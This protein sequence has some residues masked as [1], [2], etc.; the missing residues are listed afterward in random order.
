[1][2]AGLVHDAAPAAGATTATIA[3]R[4][5]KTPIEDAH[6]HPRLTGAILQR[7]SAIRPAGTYP[8][9][10]EGR[11][12]IRRVAAPTVAPPV[13]LVTAL[14]GLR[15]TW[16][17]PAAKRAISA[18]IVV[19]GLFALSSKVIGDPQIATYAAFGGFATLV[20]AGFGGTRRDKL[21][22]HAGLAVTGSV[23]LVI[24]TAVNSIT[25][26]AALVTLLVGFCVLFAG[27]LSANAASGATAALLAY[28]L[29]AASPGTIG[30]I[31]A[32][33]AG[34]WMASVAGTLAVLFLYSPPP[35]NRLRQAAWGLAQSIADLL[36]AA[37][38]GRSTPPKADAVVAAKHEL[39]A[40]FTG[41]PYRPTGLTVPDQAIAGLVEALQWCATSATQAVAVGS[42]NRLAGDVDPRLMVQ[43]AVVLRLV[44]EL[45]A[46]GEAR[47]L[48]GAVREL[49]AMLDAVRDEGTGESPETGHL[50]FHSRLVAAAT[51]S[52]AYDA[53]IAARRMD[54]A[55]AAEEVSQWWGQPVRT[56]GSAI[57]HPIGRAAS[58]VLGGH[59]SLRSIWFLNSA[60]GAVALAA[61]VAI[62]DVTNVQHAFWVVLGALSVLRTS[63]AATGATALRALVGTAIGFLIGAVL[64]VE[65]GSHSAAL[66]AVLPVAVLIAA[67]APGTAPF[68]IGQAAFT[69]TI[70]VL[71]NLIVPV[72]WKVGEV[73]IEDVAIGVG[74]SVAA[75]ALFWPR[76]ATR[77]VAQDLSEAFHAGGLYLVQAAAWA[78][79]AR[80]ESPDA[81]STVIRAEARLDDAMRGL[82]S[83]QGTKRV[84]KENVWRLVGGAQRLRL[85]AHTLAR[86]GR[87]EH[88]V[89]EEDTRLL[90]GEAARVAG[91]YDGMAA[92]LGHSPTTVAQELASLR[93]GEAR[94]DLTVPR[95][96]WVSQ[97]I[98]HLA[99]NLS[100]LEA[101][102]R[103]MATAASRPWWR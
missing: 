3:A 5:P 25:I 81:A 8:A 103:I 78:L 88:R 17:V 13:R 72:G 7:F 39:L 19:P 45:T 79:G 68:A 49:A 100:D 85:M 69:V 24:G 1:M 48:E 66:W 27:V 61:A 91:L 98:D 59:T 94:P 9:E 56:D 93:L 33:L 95:V 46:G 74:V 20:L 32:R 15:P 87:P 37:L 41:V 6:L 96:L 101:P 62:A 99:A 52:V 2:K 83:E 67:Y 65:I 92:Q 16:S 50:V 31:P 18:A 63:A 22:A 53:L 75:G 58:V 28:V 42:G 38:A 64:I 14:S 51:R 71:Y 60:R 97:H 21:V 44:A 43:S 76:G 90:M 77:V 29:P 11:M 40:A 4:S 57:R 26:L 54:L 89:D 73:R 84:S 36:D 23:L 86:T 47:G 30:M 82:L 102:G 35:V 34:W 70:T 10:E 12:Y 55:E 80:Q